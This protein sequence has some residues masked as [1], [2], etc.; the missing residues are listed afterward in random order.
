MTLRNAW[1]ALLIAINAWMKH[2]ATVA[3]TGFNWLR[4]MTRHS[5]MKKKLT[6][7]N[8]RMGF[9]LI[10]GIVSNAYHSVLNVLVF[11]SVLNV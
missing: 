1:I 10:E 6:N 8:V 11:I 2:G 3:K 5:A 4:L 9:T 7:Q